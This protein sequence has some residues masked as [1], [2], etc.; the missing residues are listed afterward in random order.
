METPSLF[1]SSNIKPMNVNDAYKN[2]PGKGRVKS[3]DYRRFKTNLL[4]SL[5]G[6]EKKRNLFLNG[7]RGNPFIL[8]T[9]LK[10][11]VPKDRYYTQKGDINR[12]KGDCGNFRKCVQD[13]IFDWL[14]IDDKYS[15]KEHNFQD[16]DD[17]GLW[18]FTFEIKALWR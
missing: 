16:P 11:F 4:D 5:S 1:I 10:I 6:Y 17:Q 15:V 7:I 12:N 18:G 8:E 14:D 2:V 9:T 3:G 13:V